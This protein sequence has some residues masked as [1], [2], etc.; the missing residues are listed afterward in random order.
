MSAETAADLRAAADLIERDGWT[1]GRYHLDGCH[2]ALGAIATAITGDPQADPDEGIFA[3]DADGDMK[4]WTRWGRAT[5]VLRWQIDG[6][7]AAISEWNDEHGRT[8]EEVVAKMREAADVEE[9][10]L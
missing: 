4:M 6:P 7:G 3:A 10:K 2:C 9:A 8:A 5:R 1:Q